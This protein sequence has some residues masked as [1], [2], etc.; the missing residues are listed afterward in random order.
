MTPANAA[1]GDDARDA[2]AAAGDSTPRVALVVARFYPDL[3]DEIA[4]AAEARVET[5]DAEVVERVPVPGAYD[6][7]LVA[8]RLARRDVVDAVAVLG[9]VVT[10]DTDHDQ[11]VT[12]AT[13]RLLGRVALD[14]DTPVGFGVLGPDMSGAEAH[15]RVEKAASA[16]D[17]ALDTHATLQRI[18]AST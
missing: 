10:G 17:A 8:D 14:R 3:A 7:P 2:S 15:E 13:A 1:D 12:H 5:R 9:V 11:V 18:A 6:A 16:V 4:A